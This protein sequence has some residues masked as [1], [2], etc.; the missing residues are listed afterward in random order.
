MPNPDNISKLVNWPTPETVTDVRAF[1]GLCSYYR[2]F[3]K[4]FSRIAHPLTQLTHKDVPFTWTDACETAFKQLKEI[5][6]G[7]DVMGYPKNDCTFILDTDAC[8]FSIGAVLSQIQDGRERVIGYASRTLSKTERNYCV[9]DRELLAVVHFTN[10][11]KHYLLGREFTVRTDH[12]ALKW[13]FS[14]KEPKNRVARWI[15]A[16]SAFHF[17][18]EYRP[19]PRHGNADGMSRCRIPQ[20]CQCADK[21]STELA[22]GP[23]ASCKKRAI[24]MS[25]CLYPSDKSV[26][27]GVKPVSIS[28][29]FLPVMLYLFSLFLGV[30]SIPKSVLKWFSKHEPNLTKCHN[31]SSPFRTEGRPTKK[32]LLSWGRRIVRSLPSVSRRVKTR[33]STKRGGRQDP[34]APSHTVTDRPCW[35]GQYSTATLRK[36]QQADADI[37]PILKWFE[38]GTRPYGPDVCA[39]SPATRHYW[40]NWACLETVQGVLCRTFHR[41]NDTGRYCQFLV[42]RA[43]KSELFKQMHATLLS[44]HLG[45]KKTREKT[46]RNFYWFDMRAEINRMVTCCDQCGANKAPTR[47]PSAPLGDMRVGSPM[48]RLATDILG[49]LPTTPR[50]NKYVLVVT[51]YFTNWVEILPVPDQTAITCAER[52][53]NEVIARFGCPLDLHSDQGGKLSQ[54][55]LPRALSAPRDPQNPHKCEESQV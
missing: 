49:P 54:F 47:T 10:H 28:L 13:L 31:L 8:D 41:R 40:N 16:L 20:N 9:T 5:L 21:K 30:L 4:S 19:G 15:E 55:H 29:I 26:V 22:C 25:S 2:R 38:S 17:S 27:R 39:A 36:R 32:T 37:G 46:L 50:G 48:D 7:P 24:D 12:Q 3:V 35:A 14:L 42:P 34:S 44:G 6:V 53:L 18:M 1:L 45:K 52:I 51:D 43:M 23:C 33:L 11:Y